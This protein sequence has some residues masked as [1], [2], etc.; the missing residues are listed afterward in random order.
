M[1]TIS[2]R[3]PRR[4]QSW[5]LAILAVLAILNH[6]LQQT[7]LLLIHEI[8]FSTLSYGPS[9]PRLES[10]T[11]AFDCLFPPC[12]QNESDYHSICAFLFHSFQRKTTTTAPTLPAAMSPGQKANLSHFL[13]FF[14]STIRITIPNINISIQR[15]RNIASAHHLHTFP[16][17]AHTASS[18]S[19]SVH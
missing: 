6:R 16:I 7:L 14:P 19:A 11:A 8:A 13:F 12:G 5:A 9:F 4:L 15:Q 18:Y 3:I 1:I 10:S 2:G 17:E